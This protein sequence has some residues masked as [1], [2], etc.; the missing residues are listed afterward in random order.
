MVWTRPQHKRTSLSSIP[1][2]IVQHIAFYIP[3]AKDFLS[4]LASFPDAT[5]IGDLQHF[6]ELSNILEPNDLWPKLQLQELTPSLVPSVRRIT[7]FFTTIYVL[8]VLDLELL[9]QCLHPHNVVE[10]LKCPLSN[11]DLHEWL[12]TSVSILPVQH[13]YVYSSNKVT[14]ARFLDQL[15]SMAHLVSLS[16][17]G[18]TLDTCDL[19]RLFD[20]IGETSNL[21]RLSLSALDVSTDI[22]ILSPPVRFGQRHLQA[23]AVWLRRCLVT[24]ITLR[25]WFVEDEDR[26]SAVE[27]LKTIF[28]S[29]T[30]EHVSM[31]M[32]SFD[33]DIQAAMFPAPLRIQSLELSYC[34]LNVTTMAALATVLRHSNIT[35]LTLDE[36]EIDLTT[37]QSLLDALFDTNVR[38]LRLSSTC[39]KDDACALIAVALPSLKLVEL[40]LTN[41]MVTDRGVEVLAEVVGCAA[42]LTSLVLSE[43]AIEVEGA[44]AL[45]KALSERPQV[46][47]RLDLS[48]NFIYDAAYLD[49]MVQRTPQ[50]LKA[51]FQTYF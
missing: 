40:N 4:F 9:Q 12:T 31:D 15:G 49:D 34:S 21:T 39:L 1:Q 23:L 16:L 20:F 29:S 26:A 22:R 51:N 41:N 38:Q 14:S 32:K 7:R 24:S 18:C 47:T 3:V 27:L 30:L 37:L 25:D 6:L 28:A 35:S 48:Y 42:S 10:L 2:S 44:T 36:S 50:I 13:V 11:E 8:K 19:D 5:S 43:N 45:V 46:T 17:Y 33:R